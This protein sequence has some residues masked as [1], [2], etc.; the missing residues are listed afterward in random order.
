VG[1][2]RKISLTRK[3]LVSVLT[4]DKNWKAWTIF[5]GR[6]PWTLAIEPSPVGTRVR[7]GVCWQHTSLVQFTSCGY[8]LDIIISYTSKKKVR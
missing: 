2:G 7:C 6:V 3:V 4:R 1:S 5:G 8:T